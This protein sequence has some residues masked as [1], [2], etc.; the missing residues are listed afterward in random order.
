MKKWLVILILLM[1]P[2]RA[3]AFSEVLTNAIKNEN[4][5]FFAYIADF[6][7]G[8][9]LI[10]VSQSGDKIRICAHDEADGAQLTDVLEVYKYDGEISIIKSGDYEYLKCFDS[11]YE[12]EDDTFKRCGVG[13]YK[14]VIRIATVKNGRADTHKNTI[15][16]AYNL[17]NDLKKKQIH[18]YGFI[19]RHNSMS[20][21]A[22]QS[23]R[24]IIAASADVMSFDICNYD[25]DTLMRYVLNTH[26]NFYTAVEYNNAEEGSRGNILLAD[27]QYIDYVISEL[28]NVEPS[29]P[30]I[31]EL[32]EKGYCFNGTNYMYTPAFNVSFGTD[33]RDIEAV[34]DV[35]EGVYFVIFGDIYTEN[36]KSVPEYSYIILKD[37]GEGCNI[38]RLE[39]GGL[40]PSAREVTGYAGNCEAKKYAWESTEEEEA[41]DERLVWVCLAVAAAAVPYLI[42]LYKR[43]SR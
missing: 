15:G 7:S 19:D 42:L 4:G 16:A 2:G 14:T 40:L 3:E 27:A 12:I 9:Y 28:F 1:L 34:Y 35:G 6:K 43:R 24:C 33:I 29:H 13:E 18:S 10:T 5:M 30:P 38:L 21:E 39:M 41:E 32:V 31:N 22:L 26:Q 17:L 20:S 25:I 23:L 11:F 37:T 8:E 36:G